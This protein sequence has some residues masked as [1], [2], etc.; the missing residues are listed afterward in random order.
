MKILNFGTHKFMVVEGGKAKVIF[1]HGLFDLY[2][3][4][5]ITRRATKITE[6]KKLCK[7]IE[8]GCMIG[9]EVGLS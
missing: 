1:I 4:D 9:F 3:I 6:L 7:F 2:K 8:N 5:A